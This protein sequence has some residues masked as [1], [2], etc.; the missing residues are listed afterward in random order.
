MVSWLD[1][2]NALTA[3]MGRGKPDYRRIA[4]LEAALWGEVFTAESKQ[5]V[6]GPTYMYWGN[7]DSNAAYVSS[8]MADLGMEE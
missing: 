6:S 3:G 8:M 4:Q 5:Y 2:A 1:S 7:N